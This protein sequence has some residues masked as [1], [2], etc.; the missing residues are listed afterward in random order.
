MK[1][2]IGIWIVS[3]IFAMV[4]SS[5]DAAEEPTLKWDASTGKVDGYTIYYGLESGVYKHSEDVGNVTELL[6]IVTALG[7]H[8]NLTYFF[9]VRAYNTQGESGDS[10][11][12][13]YSVPAW[14]PPANN[15]PSTIINIPG[16]PNTLIF[17]FNASE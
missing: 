8:P 12:T 6:N 15:H 9:V 5:V 14:E 17:N 10:N 16:V 7:I 11:E 13:T 2:L 4:I 3:I 1:R